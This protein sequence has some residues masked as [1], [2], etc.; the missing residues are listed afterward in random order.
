[1]AIYFVDL[2]IETETGDF[3]SF[4]DVFW[5]VYQRVHSHERW[6]VI[7]PLVGMYYASRFA[8]RTARTQRIG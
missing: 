5:Y 2:V 1:M 4:F 6:D 7:N 8:T 3:P